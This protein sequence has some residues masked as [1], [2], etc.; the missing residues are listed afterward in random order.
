MSISSLS[1]RDDRTLHILWGDG[2]ESDFDVVFLRRKCPC[3]S[4]IDEWTGKKKLEG[5]TVDD[6]VRPIEVKSVG[7]YALTM[8]F[9]DGHRTGIYPFRYLRELALQNVNALGNEADTAPTS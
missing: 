2:Q 9:D 7:R 5:A 8:N 1:Q 3:A 4:C 6:S